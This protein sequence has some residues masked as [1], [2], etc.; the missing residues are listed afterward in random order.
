MFVLLLTPA[1]AAALVMTRLR[2]GGRQEVGR[3]GTEK[4]EKG[5]REWKAGSR[6]NREREA[7][8]RESREW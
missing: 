2:K 6:E 5:N 8:D 7:G 1:A 3:I 4:Q